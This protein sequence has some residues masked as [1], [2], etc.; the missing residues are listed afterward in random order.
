MQDEEK[1]RLYRKYYEQYKDMSHILYNACC[2][3]ERHAPRDESIYVDGTEPIP[4][5]RKVCCS[6]FFF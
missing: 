5:M 6:R 3:I 1:L 4:P 2:Y